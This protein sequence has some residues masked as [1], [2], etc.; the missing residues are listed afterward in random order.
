MDISLNDCSVS[1]RRHEEP[2]NQA[3][4]IF[5]FFLAKS[6]NWKGPKF[7]MFFFFSF[8][9]ISFFLFE[10]F[11]LGFFFFSCFFSIFS[12]LVF[13][14]FFFFFSLKKSLVAGYWQARRRRSDLMRF[15]RVNRPSSGE[16]FFSAATLER[17]TWSFA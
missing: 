1:D 11:F 6:I 4:H 8:F 2:S 3:S 14:L 10:I 16:A 12:F 5:F 17:N 7:F 15:L 9:L 13:F